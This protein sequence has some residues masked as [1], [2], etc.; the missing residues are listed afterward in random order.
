M[1][2]RDNSPLL[3]DQPNSSTNVFLMMRFRNTKQHREILKA[4]REALGH[5]GLNGLRADDKYYSDSLWA[6]VKSYMDGCDSGIAVFEQIEDDDFNPNVSLELGYMLAQ[7]KPVLLLKEKHLKAL[8]SDVVGTL[9]RTFDSFAIAD[10]LRPSVLGWL[11]DIGIAKSPT[12]RVVLFVSY[13]GTCRC[14]MAK[15]AL[16]QA[17]RGRHLP[18]RLRVVSVAHTLGG[19]NE[20]SRG[21]RRAVVWHIRLRPLGAPPRDQTKSWPDGGCRLSPRDGGATSRGPSEREDGQF[22]YIFRPRWRC[23]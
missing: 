16:D 1:S 17:L 23:P 15:V 13:G 21:A 14:A 19:T 2:S 8:P 4:V 7:M 20:A 22:Q 12:E 5:Y 11:R 3:F 10:S 18:Y 6:N 9:Y